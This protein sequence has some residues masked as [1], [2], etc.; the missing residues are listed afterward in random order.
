L[1]AVLMAGG[2]GTRLRPLTSNRPKPMVPV[3]NRPIMEYSLDLLRR[4][5]VKYAVV[6]LHYMPH[7]IVDYFGNGEHFNMEIYYSIEDIPLGTVGGI[8]QA[9]DQLDE[10]FVVMSGDVLTN[11]DL[12]HMIRFHKS[13]GALL[14][15]ALT[16]V[17]D[18]TEFGIALLNDEGRITKYLEK[19]SWGEVFSDLANMG[20]YILEPEVLKYVPK[21]KPYD[22][23][24]NLIPKLLKQ[25]EAVFGFIA[26]P[27]YWSDIGTHEQY[28]QAHQDLLEG[29]IS[30]FKPRGREIERGVWVGDDVEVDNA[31]IKPPVVLG[32]ET[33]L[34]EG[35]KIGPYT[36]IGARNIVDRG[37]TVSRSVIWDDVY[38]GTGS[39]LREA[40]VAS[41]CNLSAGCLLMEGSVLGES[42]LVGKYAI[43]R[44]GI[45]IWPSKRVD[46]YAVVSVNLKWGIKWAREL[47]GPWGIEGAFNV[48]IT[49]EFATKLGFAIG[50]WLGRGASVAV[51]RDPYRSSR[52]I[53]RALVSGLIAAGINVFNLT[54]APTP[55]L[56]HFIK[57]AGMNC[58]IMVEAPIANPSMIRIKVLGK[59]GIEVNEDEEKIIERRFQREEYRRVSSDDV[60][61]VIY[62]TDH[63]ETYVIDACKHIR[64]SLISKAKLRVIVDCGRGAASFVIPNLL[65]RI[66]AE[67]VLLNSIADEN[68]RGH[69]VFN[70]THAIDVLS[71]MVR[72]VKADLGVFFD[73]DADRAIFIDDKGNSVPG[74]IMLAILS[75]MIL[76]EAGG[77]RIVVPNTASRVVDWVAKRKGGKVLR[78]KV[79]AKH[80]LHAIR[81]EEAVFGGEERGAFAFPEFQVG[82]DGMYALMKVMEALSEGSTLSELALSLPPT[83]TAKRSIRVPFELRGRILRRLLNEL[84]ELEIDTIDG[85]K[86]LEPH[87][88]I[89]IR[90]RSHEPL[91]DLYIE[92]DNEEEG[93]VMLR[94]YTS[95]LNRMLSENT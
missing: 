39:V 31:E 71:S 61:S 28:L 37:A 19:P 11:I 41:K 66:G 46:P 64:A 27:V 53:K 1:K 33:I 70:T 44:P 59:E 47:F 5:N 29:K 7:L 88:W 14:T 18:P 75:G 51:A 50:S 22:F 72:I 67:V 69:S 55:V 82:F 36:V 95:L 79:G 93:A 4:H 23:S 73:E 9:E 54:V 68:A 74:D 76:E 81:L 45:K 58:G 90:P 91:F 2:E 15:I 40:I 57:R 48:E 56:R 38:V 52:A 12:S 3:C 10:T 8:K 17:S 92:A 80:V 16:K 21:G 20:I 26:D 87:G 63:M 42:C 30:G 83:Y 85:I 24:K 32:D 43:V 49:P 13:H 86:V 89:L 78:T 35:S 65:E 25:E 6:T 77:G 62:P 94:R 34:K 60:G 84:R